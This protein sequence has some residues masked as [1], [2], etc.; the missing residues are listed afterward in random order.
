ML[1]KLFVIASR[2]LTAEI[3]A[4]ACDFGKQI[5]NNSAVEQSKVSDFVKSFTN[6]LQL[7]I[8]NDKVRSRSH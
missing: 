1:R 7:K 8:P 5:V 3:P 6:H 4:R 2:L